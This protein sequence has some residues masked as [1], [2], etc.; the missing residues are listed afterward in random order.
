MIYK[1]WQGKPCLLFLFIKCTTRT[2]INIV[3]F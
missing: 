3:I 2:W 1:Y